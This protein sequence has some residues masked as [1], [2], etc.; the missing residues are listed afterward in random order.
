MISARRDLRKV[1]V[2]GEP[3]HGLTGGVPI[4]A[5]GGLVVGTLLFG[6]RWI[7]HIGIFP[8]YLTDVFL[9]FSFSHVFVGWANHR[10][11]M[12]VDHVPRLL[13]VWV[14]LAW[15]SLRFLASGEISMMSFRDFAPYLYV[16]TAL[17]G[18]F[19][20]TY[21]PAETICRTASIFLL[22]L[23]GH[24]IW[25]AI[26]T[27]APEI[28]NALPAIAPSQGLHVF[29]P[30]D[31]VDE[32]LAGV[33]AALLLIRRISRRDGHVTFEWIL[34]FVMW[35]AIIAG[36]SRAGFLAALAVN[37]FG[38]WMAL[39]HRKL[40]HQSRML[41]L[42]FFPLLTGVAALVISVAPIGGRMLGTFGVVDSVRAAGAE[43]TANARFD[44]WVILWRWLTQQVGRL[45]LGVGFGLDF[46][47]ESGAS[48]VL[49]GERSVS[50]DSITPRSPHNYWLGSTARVGLLGLSL[51]L[52][53]VIKACRG[54]AQQ[55]KVDCMG[56]SESDLGRIC[57]LIV[58]SMAIVGTMGV[59]LE[60]PFG[61]IPF[62]WSV[63][64][65]IPKQNAPLVT[66]PGMTWRF[67][68]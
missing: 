54:F 9:A 52:G 15:F 4:L 36:P 23:C 12:R 27:F 62:W 66:N 22:L 28:P 33:A 43:E 35:L 64:L 7:S 3:H 6:S 20:A 17:L 21:T 50:G 37:I 67:I 51:L 18:A 19:V 56:E 39:R 25:L 32:A 26:V 5:T 14:C 53:L 45:L 29:S 57:C 31:D 60:S 34:I 68:A 1:K 46:L 11:H 13:L 24:G 47:A 59:V 40:S 2:L 42:A 30:R 49:L 48:Y 44:S 55:W 63:G 58:V 38:A 61:A 41:F 16:A 10:Y 65:L 8:I